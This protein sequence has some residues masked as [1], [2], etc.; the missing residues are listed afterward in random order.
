MEF[1]P[2][3]CAFARKASEMRDSV[4]T[5]SAL[6]RL[7]ADHVVVLN[8]L[9]R[10]STLLEGAGEHS[11]PLLVTSLRETLEFVSHEVWFHFKREEEALFP[12]TA[13]I[14]PAENAPIVGGPVYVLTEEHGVLR[15]LVARFEAEVNR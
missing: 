2:A 4:Q 7:R 9:D 1:A 3:G 6:G 15:K 10:V 11:D 8:H 14:F 13:R 12:A 5:G